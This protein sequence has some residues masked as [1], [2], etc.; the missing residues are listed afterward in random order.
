MMKRRQFMRSAMIAGLAATPVGR[1]LA[2][3]APL[4]RTP[5]DYEGP[6]YPVGDRNRTNDLV[7]GKPRDQV[8][9]FRGRVVDADGKPLARALVDIW[10]ADPLGR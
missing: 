9:H 3:Q 1:A 10:Q 4:A 6:Y 2:A 5:R 8:L 7:T